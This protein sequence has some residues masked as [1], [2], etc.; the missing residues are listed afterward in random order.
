MRR[1]ALQGAMVSL[2]LIFHPPVLRALDAGETA[3]LMIYAATQIHRHEWNAGATYG[4]KPKRKRRVQLRILQGLPGIGPG[5]A[6]ELLQSFGSVEAVMTA[7][8][9][10][11]EDVAGIGAKTATAIR[12]ILQEA[13]IPYRRG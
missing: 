3:R 10:R 8:R 5:R 11:L 1:E 12:D 4:R 6:E 9:E 7:S 2:S 13:S